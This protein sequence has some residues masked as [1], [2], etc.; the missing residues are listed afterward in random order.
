MATA[1]S[2]KPAAR[3]KTPARRAATKPRTASRRAAPVAPAGAKPPT[4]QTCDANRRVRQLLDF[5]NRQDFEDATRGFVASLSPGV[6]RKENG[7]VVWDLEQ[8]A[9]LDDEAPDSVNPSLWR[10]AQL[11][12]IHGLY[13][14]HPRIHQLRG[15]DAANMTLIEGKT[16]WIVID[17][18]TAVET[19]RAGLELANK[20]LGARP[21]V[22]V[23]Y[24]HSHADHFGGVRGVVD[25]ADVKSGKVPIIAP[26]GFMHYAISENV[27]AGNAMNRRAYSMFGAK[28]PA[29]PLGHVGCGLCCALPRGTVSLIAPTDIVEATGETRTVDGVKIEFQM[30]NGSEAPAEF[31]FYF[32]QFKAMCSSEVTSHTMHNILTP[33]GAEVRNALHWSKYIDETIDLFGDRTDLLFASHHWPTW[34]RAAIAAFLGRQRDLY[35]FIHDETLR[36]ANHGLNMEEIAEQL[37]LPDELAHDF[38]C[39]GYYGTLNHNVKAVYQ[40]YLGWWDGNPAVY[41]KL[42]RAEG[43]ARFI[44]AMGGVAKVMAEGRRAFEQG[45][46]RWAAEVMNHVMFAQP[47][48]Q[49]ARELQADILEQMGYQSEAG[50]WRDMYLTG[51]LELRGGMV[52]GAAIST[53]SMDVLGQA[54]VELIL[55]FLGVK[56]NATKAGDARFTVSLELTDSEEIFA[57]EARNGVLNNSAGRELAKPD[58]RLRM[59]KLAFF[60]LIGRQAD[61]PTLTQE[62]VLRIVGDAS[63]AARLFGLLDDFQPDFALAHG[64]TGR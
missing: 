17:P 22:A 50:T 9:F 39:R 14:I 53:A 4:A 57:L 47:D 26:D 36:L 51:A 61:V 24:T 46:Y 55:D 21:V 38:A 48:H 49:A 12:R 16:G 44:R 8:Y 28:L 58:V 64:P 13:T 63:V 5:G 33:R 56:F 35:R 1:A 10:Q 30:A 3:A 6:I 34:G 60:R 59:T 25:E 29:S 11:T 20:E 62:G 23:I 41:H 43:G 31:V 7:D 2:R 45:D 19:A 52:K 32:P 37:E 40:F 15:F 18:L 54:D 42:P 27:V